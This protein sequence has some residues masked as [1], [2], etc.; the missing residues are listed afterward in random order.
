MPKYKYCIL[1][2]N[3]LCNDCGECDVCDLD[4]NKK[5]NNCNKCLQGNFDMRGIKIDKIIEDE[6]STSSADD[7]D[8][9]SSDNHSQ[10]EFVGD[11]Y[12]GPDFNEDNMEF[13]DDVEGLSDILK[14]EEKSKDLLYEEFP[15]LI[16]IR[17]KH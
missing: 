3:K 15:G 10:C 13:I 16:R 4:R 8:N 2:S 7:V 9:N 5:C 17:K 12:T 11:D 14:D 1:D 6:N